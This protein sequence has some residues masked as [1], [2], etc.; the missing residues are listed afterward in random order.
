MYLAPLMYLQFPDYGSN[1]IM[2]IIIIMRLQN[3]D[4]LKIKY[5]TVIKDQ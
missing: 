4:R 2:I 3:I 5:Y 1:Y